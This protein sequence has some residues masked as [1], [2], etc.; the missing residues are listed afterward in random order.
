MVIKI[1]KYKS[2]F[3]LTWGGGCVIRL[4]LILFLKFLINLWITV[5]KHFKSRGR[6]QLSCCKLAS[7]FSKHAPQ[8][9]NHMLHCCVHILPTEALICPLSSVET[10]FSRL[11]HMWWILFSPLSCRCKKTDMAL[12][13]QVPCLC[14]WCPQSGLWYWWSS[15]F[16]LCERDA[17]HYKRQLWTLTCSVVH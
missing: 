3:L 9:I 2:S 1:S 12:C 13:W 7:Q 15:D 11:R 4:L 8:L 17:L 5:I 10:D 6:R 14:E 16:I